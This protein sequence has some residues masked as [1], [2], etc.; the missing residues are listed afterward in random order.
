MQEILVSITPSQA[1]F[2]L[3]ANSVSGHVEIT[4]IGMDLPLLSHLQISLEGKET[5]IFQS[6]DS[7]RAHIQHQ[8][9]FY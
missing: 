8:S 1:Y 9:K 4:L 7:S 5:F 6:Q 2:T 3:D